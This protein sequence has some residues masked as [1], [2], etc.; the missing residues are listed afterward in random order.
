LEL[1]NR[2][3]MP[4]TDVRLASRV[5]TTWG[6]NL[7]TTQM[8][9]GQQRALA[10]ERQEGCL[11]SIRVGYG[12]NRFERFPLIDLCH[13]KE[14]VVAGRFA[15]GPAADHEVP[16]A[17]EVSIANRTNTVIRVIRMS[18]VG[19]RMW[20][21][22]RL[23]DQLL[24]A[25]KKISI[26]IERSKGCL[27]RVYAYYDDSRVEVIQSA[28]MCNDSYVGF[29]REVLTSL[30]QLPP[31]MRVE[32]TRAIYVV[33]QS[34]L[35]IDSVYVFPLNDRNRGADRFGKN[36]LA[37][38]RDLRVDVS[39]QSL[40]LVTVLAVYQDRRE[41]RVPSLDLCAAHEPRVAM[42]GP[43]GSPNVQNNPQQ[44]GPS[45]P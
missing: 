10:P 12:D 7:L 8:N 16:P 43:S 44:G 38:G 1:L 2:A 3:A 35:Q 28:N 22:D 18:P 39:D 45:R 21:P 32:P 5:M 15:R 40:C 13:S 33:N 34:G 36:V 6:K 24:Q 9:P 11:Y 17:S 41:E 23:G 42:R 25:G 14:Y 27:F 20:G 31:N 26:P 4:I 30:D 29:K 37:A 19:E